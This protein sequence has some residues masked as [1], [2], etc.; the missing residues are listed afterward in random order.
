MQTIGKER[1]VQ[2]VL[3]NAMEAIPAS[4]SRFSMDPLAKIRACTPMEALANIL[5]RVA[6]EN[7]K[8]DIDAERPFS[9]EGQQPVGDGA[10]AALR[11]VLTSEA[12]LA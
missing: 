2:S 12:N 4:G 11:G 7:A 10:G 8:V 6:I 5:R 9:S 1:R 3:S